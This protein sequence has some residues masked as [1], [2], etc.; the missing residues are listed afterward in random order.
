MRHWWQLGIRNWR[1]R[2]G[3]TLAAL[4]A[5]ALGVGVVVWV[6]CAYE[7]V[8]LAIT[9][10]VWFWI[11]R[12]HLSVESVY[13]PRGTVFQVISEQVKDDPNVKYITYRLQ[14]DMMLHPLVRGQTGDTR[15][16]V[17]SPGG[18]AHPG[19]PAADTAPADEVGLT[20]YEVQ[21]VGIDPD[22]EY[23]FRIHLAPMIAHLDTHGACAFR[24]PASRDHVAHCLMRPRQPHANIR[25]IDAIA[26]RECVTQGF[27]EVAHR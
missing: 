14:Q 7:S 17:E 15:P 27:V 3:R 9:D 11:G 12:S 26:A 4:A 18:E 2:P 16:G 21:V 1:V 20:G 24:F 8:R 23:L 6:T 19:G 5:I 10:Q 25:L 22:T 13:G